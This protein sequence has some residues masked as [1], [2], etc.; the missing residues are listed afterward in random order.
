[1]ELQKH[2][3]DASTLTE[4][5]RTG[6]EEIKKMLLENGKSTLRIEI[7]EEMLQNPHNH[8]TILKMAE[9]YFGPPM[10]GDWYMTNR[11]LDWAEKE[12]VHLPPSLIGLKRD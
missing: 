8:D 9:R 2:I 11:F 6:M 4:E 12:N 1:M 3:E 7:N 10:C 5:L